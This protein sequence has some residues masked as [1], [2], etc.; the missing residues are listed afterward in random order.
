MRELRT[1]RAHTKRYTLTTCDYGR[2]LS[3]RNRDK[4]RYLIT[5]NRLSYLQSCTLHCIK[6]NVHF[7]IGRLIMNAMN[8]EYCSSPISLFYSK[9]LYIYIYINI[10]IQ[11]VGLQK[12]TEVWEKKKRNKKKYIKTNNLLLRYQKYVMYARPL[13]EEMKS[14]YE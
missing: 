2:R 11:P 4:Q 13:F 14:P 8:E 10:Y 6:S 9:N 1:N 7:F 5:F 12:R 3:K